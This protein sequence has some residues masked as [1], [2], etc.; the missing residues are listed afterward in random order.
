MRFLQQSCAIAMENSHKHHEKQKL[1]G[2]EGEVVGVEVGWTVGVAVGC[3]RQKRDI[4]K[5]EQQCENKNRSY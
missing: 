5:D 1:T 4:F 3:T 2:V